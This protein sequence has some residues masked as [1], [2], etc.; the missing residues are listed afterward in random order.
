MDSED[1]SIVWT[2]AIVAAAVIAIFY[3]CVA[4]K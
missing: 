4:F 3:M 1:K 2:V